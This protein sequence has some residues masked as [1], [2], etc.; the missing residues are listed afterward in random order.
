MKTLDKEINV[1]IKRIRIEALKHSTV[2]E[3]T[4][5]SYK[6]LIKLLKY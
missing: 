4:N 6:E 2:G 5:K 1:L 3:D